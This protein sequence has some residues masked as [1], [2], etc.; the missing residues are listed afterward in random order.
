MR[1]RLY[2]LVSSTQSDRRWREKKGELGKEGKIK[3]IGVSNFGVLHL[4]EMIRDDV[5]LPVINQVTFE[6][7]NTR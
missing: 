4:Q 6:P 3:S 5:E 1:V 2:R 7:F